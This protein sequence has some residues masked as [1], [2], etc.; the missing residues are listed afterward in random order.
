MNS[1]DFLT[2][3]QREELRKLEEIK[4]KTEQSFAEQEKKILATGNDVWESR[5]LEIKTR[6]DKRLEAGRTAELDT[7]EVYEIGRERLIGWLE[8]QYQRQISLEFHSRDSWCYGPDISWYS[9][10]FGQPLKTLRQNLEQQLKQLDSQ[11]A[12]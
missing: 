10:R 4:K 2:E 9:V 5:L 11:I 7:N 6:F 1:Q 12:E 8:R 3:C